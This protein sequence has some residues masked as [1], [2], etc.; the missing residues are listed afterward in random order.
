MRS[1]SSAW[2]WCRSV[3]WWREA[4]LPVNA[5]FDV[6]DALVDAI[7]MVPDSRLVMRSVEEKDNQ[8][9]LSFIY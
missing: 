3:E 8:A 9:E 5:L 1:E 2:R 6:I 4:L 7:M